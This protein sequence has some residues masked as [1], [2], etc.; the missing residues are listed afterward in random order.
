MYKKGQTKNAFSWEEFHESIE[1]LKNEKEM[2]YTKAL[3]AWKAKANQ[4][5]RKQTHHAV[6]MEW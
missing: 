6:V 2:A 1:G 4:N 3:Y 5:Y